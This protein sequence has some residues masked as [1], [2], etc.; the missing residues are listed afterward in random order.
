MNQYVDC[1]LGLE[2][3]VPDFITGKPAFG[4]LGNHLGKYG[5]FIEESQLLAS[6]FLETL[7]EDSARKPLLNPK[8]IIK[9]RFGTFVD[10]KAKALLLRAHQLASE[11]GMPYFANL[12]DKNQKY[13]VFSSS[14][15]SLK[16]DLNGDW[17]ID[18]LRT[19]CL[20][21]VTIDLP[22]IA[23][24]SDRD[25]S[26]F[27]EI[28]AE[29]FELATRALDIKDKALKQRANGLLPF[30]MQSVNGDHYFR[31]ENC[32]R[33]INL[34]G[35]KEAVEAFY[36]R[37]AYDSA[38]GL[39][40]AQE[41]AQ[42]I[43]ALAHKVSRKRGKLLTLA[44]RPD[45]EA[46]T[47]LAQLDVERYGIAK[48][49]FSGTREKPFYSTVNDLVFKDGQFSAE[50]LAFA[51]KVRGLQGETLTVIELEEAEHKAEELVSLTK[52]MAESEKLELW[53]YNRKS[54]YCINCKRSWFGLLH[55]CPSCGSI[56]SLTVF[57][58]FALMRA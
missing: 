57:D 18:T 45:F 14:G 3:I 30:L 41:I 22:R 48:V 51:Q 20:G 1:S 43:Q 40:L 27:F 44:I 9:V 35:L 4:P 39:E 13:S 31:L 56:G 16:T 53:T 15:F 46:S 33:T 47:R 52:R 7:A 58:R 21:C 24:E 36:E 23:Y 28:F 19:G 17:E 32:S 12:L 37:N 29:R 38:K 50:S 54:T 11:K 25:K 6:L 55:K 26:K 34:A 10:E 5:D 42:N 2:L 49:R 8:I